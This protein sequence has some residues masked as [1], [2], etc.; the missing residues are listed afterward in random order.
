MGFDPADKKSRA[1]RVELRD[2]LRSLC[3]RL[4]EPSTAE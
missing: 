3:Q 4:G 1:R 2:E